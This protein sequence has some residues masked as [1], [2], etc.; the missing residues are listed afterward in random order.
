M[1]KITDRKKLKTVY[2]P[3]TVTYINR[4]AF[5]GCDSLTT[6][7]CEA[8]EMPQ[9]WENPFENMDVEIIFGVRK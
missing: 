9:G 5:V 2:I 7:Y 6:I 1:K 3:S 4:E 8:E